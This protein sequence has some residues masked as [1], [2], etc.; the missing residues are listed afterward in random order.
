MNTFIL[1]LAISAS[2]VVVEPDQARLMET[3]Q[4]LPTFRA[5]LGDDASRENLIKT[6][7]LIRDRLKNDGYEVVEE[8]I[9]WPVKPRV[10]GRAK[11]QASDEKQEV[12]VL[13]TRNLY[14]DVKGSEKPEEVLLIGAHFDVFEGAGGADDNGT[15]TA[16]LLELARVMKGSTPKRTIRLVFFTLEEVGLIGSRRHH[17]MWVK[18]NQRRKEAGEAEERIVGMM[19]LEMLGYYTD[20]ENS[21]KSPIPPI[22][23]VFEPPTK[24]N[25]I[26]ITGVAAG[27]EFSG[28]L[29]TFMGEVEGAVPV[30]RA[31]FFPVPPPDTLRSDHAPFLLAGIPAVMITDTANF[32]N[33]HYHK[34]S[35]VVETIDEDRFFK[36]T[37]ALAHAIKKLADR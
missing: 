6:E 30:M 7:H 5:A 24:G 2:M 32:R 28:A 36:V 14:V 29:A 17:A 22:K 19:S 13:T 20:E 16:A 35:D 18:E 4:A 1:T 34:P 26:A 10:G 11:Q 8:V 25:F 27:K 37:Q 12:E 21:Q 9:E 33:P 31:D 23:D 15:G 3:L